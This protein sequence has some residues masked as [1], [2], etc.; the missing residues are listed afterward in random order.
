MSF[1]SLKLQ[2]RFYVIPSKEGHLV[3]NYPGI[4]AAIALELGPQPLTI[5]VFWGPEGVR[6]V[7]KAD[8]TGTVLVRS[9]ANHEP[10]KCSC[11]VDEYQ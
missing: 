4:I 1:H 5:F 6:V 10:F 11:A 2:S 7:L 9:V 3:R 8:Q